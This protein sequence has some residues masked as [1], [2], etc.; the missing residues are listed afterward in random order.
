MQFV[1]VPLRI[2]HIHTSAARTAQRTSP[3]VKSLQEAWGKVKN[4]SHASSGP[5]K[6]GSE[7]STLP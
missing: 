6:Y 5:L 7:M 4:S 2:R 3:L 1:N